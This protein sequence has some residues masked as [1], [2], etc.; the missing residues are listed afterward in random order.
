VTKVFYT[1]EDSVYILE[2]VIFVVLLLLF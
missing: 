2:Q 1:T